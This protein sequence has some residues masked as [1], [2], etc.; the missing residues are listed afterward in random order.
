MT[1]VTQMQLASPILNRADYPAGIKSIGWG[2]GKRFETSQAGTQP[3][4]HCIL[5]KATLPK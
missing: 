4:A 5:A 3:A 2:L 1:V